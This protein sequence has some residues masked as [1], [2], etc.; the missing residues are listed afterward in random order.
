MYSIYRII[1]G[2]KN[3]NKKMVGKREK[4]QKTWFMSEVRV[5]DIMLSIIRLTSKLITYNSNIKP[6][7]GPS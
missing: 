6:F 1:D 5:E 7:Q 4:S 2:T 3:L